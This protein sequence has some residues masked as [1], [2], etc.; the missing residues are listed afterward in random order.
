VRFVLS[1]CLIFVSCAT[2]PL[3]R[4]LPKGKGFEVLDPAF[5]KLVVHYNEYYASPPD[6]IRLNPNCDAVFGE[7]PALTIIP[8]KKGS[9]PNPFSPSGGIQFIN[10]KPDTMSI[11][12]LNISKDV[13]LLAYRGLIKKGGYI[14]KL[15]IEDF[16]PDSL[17]IVKLSVG[18]ETRYFIDRWYGMY[19]EIEIDELN[20]E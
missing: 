6:T 3:Y 19:E 13:E 4:E 15:Q 10:L 11:A 1:A 17:D 20:S 14:I 7:N 16:A 18:T 9:Y 5:G 12:L 2:A 8:W